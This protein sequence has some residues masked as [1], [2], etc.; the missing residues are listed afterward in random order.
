MV[1]WKLRKCCKKGNIINIISANDS[2]VVIEVIIGFGVMKV[3]D[4]NNR[5]EPVIGLEEL[6]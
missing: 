5:T 3:V 2:T 6:H 1:S 4:Y